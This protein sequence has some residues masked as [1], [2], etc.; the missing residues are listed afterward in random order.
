M[1][2]TI[3]YFKPDRVSNFKDLYKTDKVIQANG[4]E[5]LVPTNINQDLGFNSLAFL[6]S[7]RQKEPSWVS[8]VNQYFTLDNVQNIN[9]SLILLIEITAYNKKHFFAVVG[10]QGHFYLNKARLQSD[11][12]LRVVLNTINPSKIG[13]FDS[14]NFNANQKQQRITF[15][16]GNSVQEFGFDEN[17]E[18]LSLMSGKPLDKN[19]A[20]RISGADSLHIAS[21]LSFKD[22]GKKC[23]YLLKQFRS[24]EY[25]KTF[26]FVDKF[27]PIEDATLIAEL[28]E[29]LKDYVITKDTQLISLS[30]PTITDLDIAHSY[31]YRIGS[32]NLP[33]SEFS[34][35]K[36]YE[37]ITTDNPSLITADYL[38]K[39]GIITFDGSGHFA[40]GFQFLDIVTFELNNFKGSTFILTN[41]HW[42]KIDK[43]YATQ[44][45]K[46][47]DSIEIINAPAYLPK[48]K[49][50]ESEGSYNSRLDNLKFCI[51]DKKL[52]TGPT[53]TSK[54]EVCD[55]FHKNDKHLVCVKKLSGSAT[56]SHLFAQGSVS[57]T[58]LAEYD[59]YR[60]FFCTQTNS[61]F[62][63][64]EF[65][66]KTL[67]V[68]DYKLIY[69]IASGRKD[70][71]KKI[72]PFFSK[73]NLIT[74]IKAIKIRGA[75]AALYKIEEV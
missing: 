52:F 44:I 24:N 13:I 9:N 36:V 16:K 56:L 33:D 2:F 53:S 50:G 5:E 60:K 32:T 66:E 73:I 49:K 43:K 65:K 74:H 62:Q 39:I 71:L 21:D 63:T 58:L 48:I 34:I 3:Y 64:K 1:N 57:V 15:S 4:F 54:V 10:G 8:F 23:Q 69:A 22:L 31:E 12:G 20:T 27:K 18:L 30:F 38:S 68:S 59:K 47:F 55:A 17:E 51:Y 70:D 67:N 61:H 14:K 26:P 41:S 42:Y 45:D 19:F 7:D 37:L 11:F 29:K 35:E 25:K 75:K 46:D 28:N 40:N 6:Q 72:I